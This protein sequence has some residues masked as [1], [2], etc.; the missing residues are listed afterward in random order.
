VAVI[1]GM[2][3]GACRRTGGNRTGTAYGPPGNCP[4]QNFYQSM[5]ANRDIMEDTDD[6]IQ[7]HAFTC[8]HCGLRWR[9]TETG[10]KLHCK[11]CN[12]W[13]PNP[14]AAPVPAT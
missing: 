12:R 3:G 5:Q 14:W 10:P 13:F 4:Y 6:I 8:P 1:F 2:A 9:T 11:K 7:D